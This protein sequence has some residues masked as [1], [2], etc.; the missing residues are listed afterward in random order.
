MRPGLLIVGLALVAAGA[1]LAAGRWWFDPARQP[2]PPAP[3]GVEVVALGGHRGPIRL[4]DLSGHPQDFDQFDGRPVVVNFW[5]TWC[6][7]CVRELPLLD[8]WHA[9]RDGD[10]IAVV[11]IA[12]E[13]DAKLVA[14][15]VAERGLALPVWIATPGAVDLSTRLGNLRGVLPYSVLIGADGR[16]LGQKLGEISAGELAEWARMGRDPPH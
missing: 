7:P 10:G 15:F 6:P 2:A 13:H 5:A 3:P 9:R 14:D 11:A 16:L 4:P 8:E 1:G 12:L